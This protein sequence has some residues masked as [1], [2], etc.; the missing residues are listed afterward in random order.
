MCMKRFYCAL[1]VITLITLSFPSITQADTELLI[2]TPSTVNIIYTIEPD[3]VNAEKVKKI[4]TKIACNEGIKTGRRDDAQLFVRVE[5]HA[6]MYLLYLDFSREVY[7]QVNGKKYLTTGFV[8][9]RY[10]KNIDSQNE[11]FDDIDFF[12]EEFFADYK[13]AN[14]L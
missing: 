6:D 1:S 14:N 7:F 5:K 4:V 2:K 11:L 10:A 8:W 9:G 12:A 3:E 13:Q